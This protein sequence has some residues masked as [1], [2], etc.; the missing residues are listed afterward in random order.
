M[1]YL[2]DQSGKIEQTNK[3]TVIGA[4]N[5]KSY[6]IKL[7]AKV[8]RVLQQKCRASLQGKLFI[9]RTFAAL[10][11]LLIKHNTKTMTDLVIDIEYPG[12]EKVIKE[13]ILE[14]LRKEKLTE[15]NLSFGRIGNNPKAHF[16]A[17]DVF[18]GKKKADKIITLAGIEKLVIKRKRPRPKRLKST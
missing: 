12:K 16:A 3:D 10:V 18:I 15:P 6:A 5:G 13:V 7:P 2:V 9:Y 8:K 4:A 1:I 11:F 14:L 17:Y